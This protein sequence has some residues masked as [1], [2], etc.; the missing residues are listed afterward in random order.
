[1]CYIDDTWAKLKVSERRL[2]LDWRTGVATA[3]IQVAKTL[4]KLRW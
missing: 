2:S 1:M 4:P 3:E